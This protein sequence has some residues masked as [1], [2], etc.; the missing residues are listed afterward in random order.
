M[1][2][3]SN[4]AQ[5]SL[6]R[7]IVS[8]S[9]L[10]ALVAPQRHWL[11]CMSPTSWFG[12]L[13]LF[14]LPWM[15]ISCVN[16]KGEVT[17]RITMSGAQLVWGGATDHSERPERVDAQP[18]GPEVKV[19]IAPDAF[20]QQRNP[21]WIAGRCLLATYGFLLIACLLFA[22]VRPGPRRALAGLLCCLILLALLLSGSW[23]LLEN[24]VSPPEPSQMFEEWVVVRYTPWYYASYLVNV[25]ALLWFGIELW[26]IRNS[27]SEYQVRRQESEVSLP[28][29]S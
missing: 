15:H 24:P 2:A 27:G 7:T 29:V 18:G 13:V 4:P 8:D 9:T 5:M 16:A 10:S 20:K 26:V 12:A 11:R 25:A 3:R 17:S 28:G 1:Q 22:L 14:F 21:N 19:E 6:E 23:L